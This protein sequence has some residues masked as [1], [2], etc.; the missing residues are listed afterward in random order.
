MTMKAESSH[1]VQQTV[2]WGIK[3]KIVPSSSPPKSTTR[4]KSKCSRLNS[5]SSRKRID[6][7]LGSNLCL[8]VGV[9]KNIQVPGLEKVDWVVKAEK[10]ALWAKKI[11]LTFL[12]S[13][14]TK[15]FLR[16]LTFLRISWVNR[17]ETN[18]TP[19]PPK[20]NNIEIIQAN[21]WQPLKK[22]TKQM[23]PLKFWDTILMIFELLF[24]IL[25]VSLELM[26]SH[27]KIG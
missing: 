5:S 10:T 25:I 19:T 12:I 22:E 13:W 21:T 24:L 18:N 27:E 23:H 9:D 7:R 11:T 8:Y 14:E 3:S 16:E 20:I 2:S 26:I 1:S 15:D 4:I 17:Q 6:Y